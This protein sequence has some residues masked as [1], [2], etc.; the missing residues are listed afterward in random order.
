MA[1]QVFI[2]FPDIIDSDSIDDLKKIISLVNDI[3]SNLKN[4]KEVTLFYDEQNVTSFIDSAKTLIE[5]DIEQF[6]QRLRTLLRKTS[7]RWRNI[8]KI[9]KDTVYRL[10]NIKK[11]KLH[12][13][14]DN[15]YAIIYDSYC[16]VAE[17]NI[18][19]NNTNYL[20]ITLV[21]CDYFYKEET[22]LNVK[23]IEKIIIVRDFLPILIDVI[24]REELPELLKIKRIRTYGEF[25]LWF[26][27]LK[28][29]IKFKLK[30]NPDYE[31]TN[32]IYP[33]TKRR[34]YQH[35]E[36]K[37]FWYF[38]FFHKDNKIHYEVFSRMLDYIGEGDENGNLAPSKKVTKEEKAKKEKRIK[39]IMKGKG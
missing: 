16:E 39:K 9:Q 15:D 3:Q 13:L 27:L 17:R 24:H 34:I 33:P 10:W 7:S 14:A 21:E 35:K 4:D 28:G 18:Q 22:E 11:R 36:S 20:I 29:D 31:P 37:Q 26:K 2:V 38:D 25:Q 23:K 32:Y 30:D 6:T 1:A 12:S 8:S 5:Q 19:D